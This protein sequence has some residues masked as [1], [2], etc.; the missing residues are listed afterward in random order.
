MDA[1]HVLYDLPTPLIVAGLLL[2]MLAAAE[3]ARRAGARHAAAWPQTHDALL[4]VTSAMLLLLG[5]MLAFSFSMS[6]G[7]FQARQAA[8]LAET[9]AIVNVDLLADL[10]LPE[11]RA[12][13]LVDLRAFTEQRIAFVA[14]GH[15]RARERAAAEASHR[16]AGR[17]WRVVASADGYREPAGPNLSLLA[18]AVTEMIATARAREAARATLVPQPLLVMLF[19][20]AVLAST[21]VSF[22]FRAAGLRGRAVTVTF[23]LLICMIIYVVID[24]DRPRRGIMR[25]DPAPLLQ[26]L[27]RIERPSP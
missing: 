18:R 8:L 24:L 4:N 13:V 9:N 5:L 3:V 6:V 23:M 20:L 19:V 16:I 11:P 17:I 14:V 2:V 10:L 26:V 7:R 12:A 27:D 22:N 1:T 25:L 15:D 21:M